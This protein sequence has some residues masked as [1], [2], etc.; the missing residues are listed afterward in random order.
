LKIF[1]QKKPKKKMKTIKLFTLLFLLALSA[2]SFGQYQA[3]PFVEPNPS[4]QPVNQWPAGNSWLMLQGVY[5]DITNLNAAA[6]TVIQGHSNVA[7]NSTA[8]A[9]A[10][11]VAVGYITS[12]SA[13][14][15]TITLPTGTLLGAALNATKGTV[16]KLYIDNTAGASTVTI[17][18][19]TN[20][21]LSAAAVAGS[22]AGAG[23]LTV[24]SGVTGVAEF[25][26]IFSSATAY[27]F[28]RTA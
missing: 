18:V 1:N 28:S 10:A 25:T 26:L 14:A 15:T 16:F 4:Y 12:T 20:G 24:P 7:I 19:A 9:T 23:L 2:A 5:T 8:T 22:G 17:A 21:I 6:A 11:Q 27:V 13:S 3:V